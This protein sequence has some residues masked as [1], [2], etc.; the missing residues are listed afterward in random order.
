[1]FILHLQYDLLQV[2][3][4]VLLL[5]VLPDERHVG[6]QLAHHQGQD[7]A[8]PSSLDEVVQLSQGGLGIIE[9]LIGG[10]GG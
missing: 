6:R 7:A 5:G 3:E 2:L 4:Q 9:L 8:Q 1:M 10:L